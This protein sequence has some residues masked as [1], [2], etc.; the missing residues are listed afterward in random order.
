[1]ISIHPQQG[2]GLPPVWLSPD[3]LGF[4]LAGRIDPVPRA[5]PAEFRTDVIAVTRKGEAR[6]RQIAED[7]GICE[8]CSHRWL[9]IADSEEGVDRSGATTPVGEVSAELREARKRIKLL[10]QE[11]RDHAPCRWL[12]IPEHQPK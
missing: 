1:M 9:K 10:E 7:F 4:V 5:F 3:L 12:P 2:L 8:A 6:L 11:G